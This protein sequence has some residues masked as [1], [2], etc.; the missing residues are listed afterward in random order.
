MEELF[1]S[2]HLMFNFINNMPLGYI[3][4]SNYHM[5]PPSKIEAKT[6]IQGLIYHFQ[7]FCNNLPLKKGEVYI[8]IEAPK[9]EFGVYLISNATV[10]PYRC[11]VR[12]PG[13]FHLQGINY[14]SKNLFLADVVTIIG[15]LDIV[16]G[17]IDR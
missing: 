17:E 4:T 13:Y 12:S 8:G 10:V 14:M 3:K 2:N 5:T 7:Y 16:F 11:K 6:T 1:Q 15:T 9:G